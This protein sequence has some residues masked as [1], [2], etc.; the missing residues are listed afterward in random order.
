MTQAVGRSRVVGDYVV[1]KRIGEGSFS[2]VWHGRHKVHGTEVAIKEIA[3]L[4]LNKKLQ[5]SLMSE[6][7][8][9]KR[10]NHPNIISLYDIIQVPGKIHLVLEYCRGGDLSLYI[11][12]HGRV[13]E[14]TAKYFM[15]QLAAG[16]Q[17]LRDN[18]LIHRDLKPQNLL[19]SQND[20]KSVL[21]IADFGFAR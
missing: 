6:I 2:V 3:M 1:G 10:I 12:H 11:Q 9:L 14:T 7:F 18:N 17:V 13:P 4:R 15:Q 16:L 19:L 5:E 8:I 20:E 21:K